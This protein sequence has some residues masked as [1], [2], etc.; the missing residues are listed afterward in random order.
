MQFNP[1][2]F[3]A[4]LSDIGQNVQWRKSFACTCTSNT[5]G[6]ADPKHAF[7]SGKGRIW[8]PPIDTITGVASQKVQAEWAKFGEWESGDL[9]LS[10]PQNSPL[11]D[12]GQFDRITMQNATHRFSES[13]THGAPT[14]RML[15]PPASIERVFWLDTTGTQLIE[16]GLPSV[17]SAG[18]LTWPNGG[19]PPQGTKY[20]ISGTR[21]NEY[22][23]FGQFPGD[24]NQ[25][26]G[27]RLPKRVV[28]R[29]WDLFAR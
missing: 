29:K 11:W 9:V 12:A 18:Y 15:Q 13:M 16:G 25:H 22:F 1:G 26:Q 2:A 8:E 6:S 5:S 17:D 4:F 19:S 14:E 10:V 23:V 24:R 28:A 7:C 3:D 21:Y 20:S 27:M